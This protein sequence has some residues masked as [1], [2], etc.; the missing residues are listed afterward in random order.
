MKKMFLVLLSAIVISG[1]AVKIRKIA[2]LPYGTTFGDARRSAAA[3]ETW[4]CMEMDHPA[5]RRMTMECVSKD[6]RNDHL[7]Y[8]FVDRNGL[9]ILDEAGCAD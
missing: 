1:C 9:F 4:E 6:D 2:D 7:C 8:S 5:Q 3:A